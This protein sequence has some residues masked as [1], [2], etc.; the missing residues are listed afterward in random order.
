MRG[1]LRCDGRGLANVDVVPLVDQLAI[2]TGKKKMF[3]LIEGYF[4]PAK[5]AWQYH[6]FKE[7]IALLVRWGFKTYRLS[8]IGFSY[9]GWAGAHL[10]GLK[11]LRRPLFKECH[12]YSIISPGD[13]SLW[14]SHALDWAIW[15][16][17]SSHAS[18]FTSVPA[19][20]SLPAG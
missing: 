10:A 9:G 12:K 18:N 4:Y 5:E 2:I 8:I 19:A 15:Y 7:D 11:F 6:R 1:R 17:Q 14:L 16:W 3:D 13:H 20:L